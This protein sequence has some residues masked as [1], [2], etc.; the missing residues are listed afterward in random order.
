[1]TIINNS[2]GNSVPLNLSGFQQGFETEFGLKAEEA[3]AI[4]GPP[5]R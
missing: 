5:F 1:L 4:P 3:S 2:A